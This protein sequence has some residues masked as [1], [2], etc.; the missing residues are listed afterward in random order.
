MNWSCNFSPFFILLLGRL[1]ARKNLLI[2]KAKRSILQNLV[3]AL[4]YL[5]P[6]YLVTSYGGNNRIDKISFFIRFSFSVVQASG[7]GP[8]LMHVNPTYILRL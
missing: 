1:E 3:K 7:T 2:A 8:R 6:L 4:S 5:R